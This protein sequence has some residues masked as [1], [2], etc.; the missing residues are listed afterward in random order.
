MMPTRR[1]KMDTKTYKVT[2]TGN[3]EVALATNGRYGYFEHN[4]LGDMLG[5]GL[6]F[7]D[8]AIYDYDGVAELPSEVVVELENRGVDVTYLKESEDAE[9]RK[10]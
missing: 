2:N 5:G 1:I 6:W 9:L 7:E 10:N 8:G 4:E 3:F